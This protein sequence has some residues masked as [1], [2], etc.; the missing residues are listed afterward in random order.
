[1]AYYFSDR[2]HKADYIV[3]VSRSIKR[4]REMV[5][6]WRTR[7]FVADKMLSPRLYFK[8]DQPNCVFDSRSGKALEHVLS[9][10]ELTVLKGLDKPLD[11]ELLSKNCSQ[12]SK[13]DLE[14]TVARLCSKH[15]LFAEKRS[16]DAFPVF[17][18]ES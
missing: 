1:M 15:L 13:P 4:L 11:L 7:W 5:D 17:P 2:N 8:A 6:Y 12:F 16:L 3:D 9:D 14:Q 10:Q 18:C